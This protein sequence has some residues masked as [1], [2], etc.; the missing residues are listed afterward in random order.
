MT[1]GVWLTFLYILDYPSWN[2]NG[3]WINRGMILRSIRG[4]TIDDDDESI[5][6]ADPS[7]DRIVRSKPN[8]T[9][10][11]VVAGGNGRGNKSN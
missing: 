6:F 2:Q 11:E 5:Y 10:G 9:K 3:T 1:S 8:L 7:A 4:I